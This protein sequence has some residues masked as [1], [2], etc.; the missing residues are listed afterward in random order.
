MTTD[1]PIE[2]KNLIAAA[3]DAAENICDPLDGLVEKTGTDPGASHAQACPSTNN[4]LRDPDS[5]QD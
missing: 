2:A 3:I 5:N 4:W 1:N